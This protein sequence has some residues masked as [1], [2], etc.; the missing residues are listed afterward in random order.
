MALQIISAGVTLCVSPVRGVGGVVFC[1]SAVLSVP[2]VSRQRRLVSRQRRPN[3]ELC[4]AL[5]GSKYLLTR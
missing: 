1:K 4:S 5:S 2:V 3:P